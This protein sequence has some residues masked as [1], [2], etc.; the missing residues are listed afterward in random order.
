MTTG[1]GTPVVVSA[2]GGAAVGS[3]AASELG[4][5]V[6]VGVG[7]GVAAV[8][9]GVGRTVTVGRW[10]ALNRIVP[11]HLV[12]RDPTSGSSV[13]PTMKA[14]GCGF[15]GVQVQLSAFLRV[16]GRESWEHGIHSFVPLHV[17]RPT[18]P[19]SVLAAGN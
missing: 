11:P 7:P 18:H 2:V 1:F 14:V 4:V 9:D 15:S 5:A 10:P 6:G 12:G 16:E 3:A 17:T 19:P 13:P 8:G